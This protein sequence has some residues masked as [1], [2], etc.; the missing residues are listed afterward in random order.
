[1]RRDLQLRRRGAFR[2]SEPGKRGYLHQH[3]KAYPAA[4]PGF[5][6]DRRQPPGLANRA[7][8]SQSAW[9]GLE[10]PASC[11]GDGRNRGSYADLRRRELSAPGR[12]QEPPMARR[13][14]WL[15]SAAAVH[16]TVRFFGRQSASVSA[17]LEG[18]FGASRRRIRSASEQWTAARALPRRQSDLSQPRHQGKNSEYV[19]RSL[20]GAGRAAWYP[21]RQPGSTNLPPRQ[22]AGAGGGYRPGTERRALY[23]HELHRKPRQCFNRQPYRPGDPY[24]RLQR[25]RREAAGAE[26]KGRKPAAPNQFPLR[27]SDAAA[28]RGS[29]AEMET[30]GL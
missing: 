3:G 16:E 18:A 4:L 14:G 24:P 20:A 13:R 7:A 10:L 2:L 30:P 12:L 21:K 17:R 27:A 19:R 5:R 23:A 29:R 26:R 28:W 25:D 8:D 9:R 11:R 15:R 1:F 6:T 22:A